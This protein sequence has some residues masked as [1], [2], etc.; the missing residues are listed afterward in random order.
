MGARGARGAPGRV[1]LG[2]DGL[3]RVAGRKLTAHPTAGR[4][5][6]ANQKPKTRRDRRVA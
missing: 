4:N 5:P 1:G 6:T 3:G 2:Q